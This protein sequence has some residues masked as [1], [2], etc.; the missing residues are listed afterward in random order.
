MILIDHERC[1]LLSKE[2]IHGDL[3]VIS[4]DFTIDMRMLNRE[5]DL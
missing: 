5:F 4:K 2:S 3:N 1:Q